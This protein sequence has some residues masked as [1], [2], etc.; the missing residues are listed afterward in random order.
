MYPFTF[1]AI[2]RFYSSK[3]IGLLLA[4]FFISITLLGFSAPV[5]AVTPVSPEFEEQVLQVIREHPD[6]I[7]ESLKAYQQRIQQQI[8]Q[9]QQAF[10]ETL[11]T[12]P[13]AVIGESPTTGPSASKIVMVEFSDFQCPYCARAHQTVKQFM[14]KHQQEVTLTYKHYPLVSIHPQAMAAAK[15]AWAAFQQGKFWQYHDQL[16]T[17]QEKLGES[18]YLEIAQQLHLDVNLFNRD[19]TSQA[20]EMAIR[21]DIELAE[22]VGITGTP[23]FILNDQVFSGAIELEDMEERLAHI[24]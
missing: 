9:A 16:F 19:R 23:F 5:Q 4:L 7:L 14:R 15:A 18:L 24:R 1:C 17:Q 21:Q 10:V 22:S 8:K 6:V 2:A 12:N 20:A 11:T 3:L 13:Q